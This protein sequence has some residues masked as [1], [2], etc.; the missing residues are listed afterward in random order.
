MKQKTLYL[1]IISLVILF[2]I[3][4]AFTG[5]AD[6]STSDNK[7]VF[8]KIVSPPVPEEVTFAGEKVP[9]EE[10]DIFERLDREI[11]VN[12]F[13]HSQTIRYLKLTKRYFKII[14][15]ILKKNNIPEDFKY[16]ALAESGFDPK[17]VSPSGAAGIWQFMKSAAK[18]NGLEISDD[19]DERYNIEKATEAACQYLKKSYSVYGNWTLVAASYNTGNGNVSQQIQNQKEN[20]YYNLLFSEETNRY[21]FR[22]LALKYIIES[23]EKY[24]FFVKESEVYPEIKFK[25]V[26]VKESIPDLAVFAKDK[27]TNYKMLK[28]LNPWLRST[29][30]KNENKKSYLIKI[31]EK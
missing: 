31:P 20:D 18:E 30:L 10:Y 1:I 26:E 6:P 9:T 2:T 27:G 23:P 7:S 13:F 15:P 22:I 19:V 5:P 28:I 4:I 12:S 25:N 16:L 11:T 21:V 29:S 3:S 14:E 24:G 17:A 8:Q